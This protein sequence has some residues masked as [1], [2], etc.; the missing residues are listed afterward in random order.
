MKRGLLAIGVDRYDDD[1]LPDLSAAVRGAKEVARW[2]TGEGM[3]V[4]LLTDEREPV[5]AERTHE[6]LERLRG[7]PDAPRIDQLVLYFAGHGINRGFCETWLLSHATRNPNE[8]VNLAASVDR[9]RHVSGIPHV[10]F[11]SDACRSAAATIESQSIQGQ[12]L[13]SGPIHRVTSKVDRFFAARPGHAAFEVRSAADRSASFEGLFTRCLLEALQGAHP[14]I[15]VPVRVGESAFMAVLAEGMQ[16]HLSRR[17]PARAAELG[18]R[19]NQEPDAIVESRAPMYLATVNAGLRHATNPPRRTKGRTLVDHATR[20]I[21][22]A[23]AGERTWP[24][25]HGVDRSEAD[26]LADDALRLRSLAERRPPMREGACMVYGA[27]VASAGSGDRSFEVEKRG[28]AYLIDTAQADLDAGVHHPGAAAGSLCI[29]LT[30]GRTLLSPLLP[31]FA[32]TVLFDRDEVASVGL[33]LA[34]PSDRDQEIQRRWAPMVAEIGAAA[35]HGVLRAVGEVGR[36]IAAD[37]PSL[38][39]CDPCIG[40]LILRAFHDVG[41]R[42]EARA[43]A[44]VVREL[45]ASGELPKDVEMLESVSGDTRPPESKRVRVGALPLLSS[46][47]DVF[48][49]F[50]ERRSGLSAQVRRFSGRSLWCLYEPGASAVLMP[51]SDAGVF[52]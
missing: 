36:R 52:R 22:D 47:W 3:D 6:A 19:I 1:L 43:A 39:R 14:E 16:D 13:F 25:S 7:K 4:V 31:G 51:K 5:T 10:V 23:A 17:I 38:V 29:Q 18:L 30:D 50:P 12:A 24:S 27:H 35:R 33:H 8:A 49:A 11:V 20:R 21:L 15:A 41:A 2:A 46:T 45:F 40:I 26:A 34:R 42:D 48:D 37:L 44:Q 9:A 32:G 28:P